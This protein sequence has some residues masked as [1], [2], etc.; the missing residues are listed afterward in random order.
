MGRLVLANFE[1]VTA[2]AADDAEAA[3]RVAM[4]I[5]T[6]L[7][8]IDP[9]HLT[10]NAHR[11]QWNHLSKTAHD[12]LLMLAASG[13]LTE[14]RRQFKT[15]SNALIEMVQ[16]FGVVDTGPVYRAMCPMFE[17]GESSWLQPQEAITNPYFG[18]MMFT[19]G[20]IKETIVEAGDPP[21]GN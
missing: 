14:Q 20:E 8:G 13:D 21:G 6:A 16:A 18:A 10:N 4:Q 7:H 2:L 12:T 17:E 5:D 9:A 3:G 15:F 11:R 19:C 1:L